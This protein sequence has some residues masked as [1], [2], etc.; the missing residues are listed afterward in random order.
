MP[1]TPAQ[2]ARN[3]LACKL[4]SDPGADV[5]DERRELAAA[6]LEQHI[7]EARDGT[8]KYPPLSEQTKR[9]LAALLHPGPGYVAA[10][11]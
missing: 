7:I 5:S 1:L 10:D 3:R 8:P 4:R 9:E 2:Q 6:R 11:D